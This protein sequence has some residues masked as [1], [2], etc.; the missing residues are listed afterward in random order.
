M[1]ESVPYEDPK[2]TA[3]DCVTK[4]T[5]VSNIYLDRLKITTSALRARERNAHLQ[6]CRD[7]AQQERVIR[8]Q[9]RQVAK[10][11]TA[12][13]QIPWQMLVRR[14]LNAVDHTMHDA[15]HQNN[16]QFRGQRPAYKGVI[17][18]QSL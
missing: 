17:E 4:A 8:R 18:P 3:M 2:A 16:L 14:Q 15:P 7:G 12:C 6:F 9:G 5:R 11:A 10:I 1:S 13:P